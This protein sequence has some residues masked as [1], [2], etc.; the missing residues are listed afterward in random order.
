MVNVMMQLIVLPKDQSRLTS[1]LLLLLLLSLGLFEGT[2]R[3]SAF[4]EVAGCLWVVNM[5]V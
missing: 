3:P 5:T 4:G 2:V 1:V